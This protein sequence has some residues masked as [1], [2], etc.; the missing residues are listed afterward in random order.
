MAPAQRF[1]RRSG[2]VN[3]WAI[4][5]CVALYFAILLGIAWWTGR[6]ADQAG[7]FLGN[8]QSPWYVV[9]FGLIGDSLSGVTFISVPG[10]VGTQRCG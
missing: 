2:P 4:L 1:P 6:R 5:G 3:P 7:Y 9:A 10:Q 8:R